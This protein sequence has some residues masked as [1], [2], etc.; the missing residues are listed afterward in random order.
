MYGSMYKCA[1]ICICLVLCH[2]Q[3]WAKPAAVKCGAAALERDRDGQTFFGCIAFTWALNG[4]PHQSMWSLC[5]QYCRGTCSLG[6]K[7]AVSKILVPASGFTL[8]EV[9][10]STARENFGLLLRNLD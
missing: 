2:E 4:L 5:G 7:C 1:C 10:G 8:K 3:T 9:G 6:F